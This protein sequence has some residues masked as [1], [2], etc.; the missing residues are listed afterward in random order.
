MIRFDVAIPVAETS[1]SQ[2]KKN[3]PQWQGSVIPTST[4]PS[5]ATDRIH[6]IQSVLDQLIGQFFREFLA[7]LSVYLPEKITHDRTGR[8]HIWNGQVGLRKHYLISEAF[9]R[10]DSCNV[11]AKLLQ[12]S[13][14]V[15]R[16]LKIST[17]I[18]LEPPCSVEGCPE[19]TTDDIVNS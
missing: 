6:Y 8:L 4:R 13:G 2:S 15:R 19:S 16:R 1:R 17:A 14:R 12:K 9:P 11:D 3:L 7:P 10:T 5:A 18:G